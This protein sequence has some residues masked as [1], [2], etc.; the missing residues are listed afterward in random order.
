ML[1]LF[2]L[3]YL[4]VCN[5]L[6]WC[7]GVLTVLL[8]S[9]LSMNSLNQIQTAVFTLLLHILLPGDHNTRIYL[10]LLGYEM[11][12]V[13]HVAC[14]ILKNVIFQQCSF[15][16]YLVVELSSL[17]AA[18]SGPTYFGPSLGSILFANLQKYSDSNR[19]YNS[20][21]VFQFLGSI[22]LFYIL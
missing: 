13:K 20:F 9:L 16:K 10:T 6:S 5:R 1:S 4:N 8:L 14:L 15:K 17:Q 22:V 3:N 18:R 2:P 12:S 7:Q 19:L 21:L 11:P